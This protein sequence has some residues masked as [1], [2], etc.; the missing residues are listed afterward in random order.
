MLQF[1]RTIQATFLVL[2][3]IFIADF[4]TNVWVGDGKS[5]KNLDVEPWDKSVLSKPESKQVPPVNKYFGLKPEINGEA[6]A[7][8]KRREEAER[9]AR[10]QAKKEEKRPEVLTI[11]Q[12]DIHLFGVSMFGEQRFALFKVKMQGDDR[13]LKL[14][15]GDEL[16][17][18][19]QAFTVKVVRVENSSVRLDINNMKT[20][21]QQ[22]FDLALFKYD[23]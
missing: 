9:L 19:E 22:I 13:I 21:H 15:A 3:V 10:E 23:F 4:F 7:M 11:G 16:S 20:N 6:E 5:N 12:E 2:G 14:R 8:R 17:I 1:N 18:Q